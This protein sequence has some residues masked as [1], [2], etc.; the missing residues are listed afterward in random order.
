M[1]ADPQLGE[2]EHALLAAELARRFGAEAQEP[3]PA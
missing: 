3:I 2:P 1:A